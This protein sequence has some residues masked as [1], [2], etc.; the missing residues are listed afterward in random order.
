MP[1]LNR[2]ALVIVTLV[3][4]M[5]WASNAGA[6]HRGGLPLVHPVP[7]PAAPDQAPEEGTSRPL[8]L[9]PDLYWQKLLAQEQA[10]DLQEARRT[11]LALANI[12][13]RSPQQGVALL[14]L[15]ELAQGQ[16]ET[17]AALELFGLVISLHP[18]TKEASQ[19]CLAAGALELACGLPKGTPVQSLRQFL[20]KI[21]H[22]PPGYSPELLQT[23]L[24][25]GWQAVARQVLATSPLPL[26]LVEEI[27]DLWDRQPQGFGPPEAARLLAD[28]LQKNGL[29]ED[30]RAL[31]AKTRNKNKSNQEDMLKSYSVQHSGIPGGCAGS[32]GTLN[33]IP[34]QDEQP[35]FSQAWRPR[36]QAEVEA[37]L[38]PGEAFLTWF[39]PRPAHAAWLE[40][41]IPAL[42]K[43]LLYPWSPPLPD[44]TQADLARCYLPERSFPRAVKSSSPPAGQ[45]HKGNHG[46]FAQYR[47]G[48]NSLQEGHP[49][50][51]QVVFQ[52]LA[53]N[54][55][56]LWQSLARV[57][58]ADLEL[59][60][61]QAEPA[62]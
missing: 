24:K 35:F 7:P 47:L 16:G 54:H 49:D 12:F 53:Q 28:L 11:G 43:Q 37:A 29:L 36:W 27:L 46:P 34:P 26:A 15:G 48:V 6:H 51:A 59:S 61:L 60:R 9:Q 19:A 62:P 50:E 52:E 10:G 39:L 55:D 1:G 3:L 20:G 45:P 31:L 57:R 4:V 5:A 40:G 41:K 33:L 22:L 42:E 18:G 56:P 58:L 14:K 8:S 44:R 23:A 30:A 25:T 21:S 2:R 32:A 13:P 38:F 17:A